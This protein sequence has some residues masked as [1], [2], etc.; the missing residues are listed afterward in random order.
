MTPN[1]EMT[2][3]RAKEVLTK[4][5]SFTLEKDKPYKITDIIS[6]HEQKNGEF[7]FAKGFLSGH[8]AGV[9][10]SQALV[11]E[12]VEGYELILK[13]NCCPPKSHHGNTCP[14]WIAEEALESARRM[15]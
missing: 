6:L 7:W 5:A 2:L 9:K 10:E 15:S 3:E 12:L 8:A 14:R 11:K 13:S 1:P 4:G